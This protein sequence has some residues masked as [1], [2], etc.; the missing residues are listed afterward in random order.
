MAN[1]EWQTP[2]QKRDTRHYVRYGDAARMGEKLN[3]AGFADAMVSVASRQLQDRGFVYDRV[4]KGDDGDDADDG[5][6]LVPIGN[7]YADSLV[8]VKK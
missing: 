1:T 7:K 8:F 5:E 4:H 6:V 3:I 2:K